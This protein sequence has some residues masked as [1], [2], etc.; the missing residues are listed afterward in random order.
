MHLKQATQQGIGPIASILAGWRR[1]RKKRQ[2]CVDNDRGGLERDVDHGN[3]EVLKATEDS[4]MF[5]F[6]IVVL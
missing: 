5:R 3:L 4:R 6:P 2:Y 1:V